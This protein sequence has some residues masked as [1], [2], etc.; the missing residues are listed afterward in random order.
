MFQ[1]FPV[2]FLSHKKYIATKKKIFLCFVL[3][4]Q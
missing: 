4:F 1:F 3:D 2:E